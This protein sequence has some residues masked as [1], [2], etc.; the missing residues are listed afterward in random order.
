MKSRGFSLVEVLVTVAVISLAIGPL[1]QLMSS[2][3]RMSSASIYEVMAVHYAAEVTEQLQWLAQNNTIANIHSATGK[4]L[5]D[6][7]TDPVL[8][9]VLETPP[10]ANEPYMVVLAPT[11]IRLL[12]SPLHPNFTSRRLY[13]R[14]LD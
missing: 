10:I 5:Q 4:D 12:L 13:V 11:E 8:Q 3:N 2:T 1:V 9:A 7:L 6:I 14:R